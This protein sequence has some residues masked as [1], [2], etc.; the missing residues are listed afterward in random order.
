MAGVTINPVLTSNAPGTFGV[1]W[2]GLMQ[3][4]AMPDPAVRFFLASGFLDLAAPLPM[5]GG[6]AISEL[7]PT[8]PASP[9]LTPDVSLQGQIDRATNIS[10]V[11]AALSLTG[12][13]VFDQAYGMVNSPQSPVPLG[14]PGGQVMFYRLGSGARIAVAADASLVGQGSI[15]T[16]QVS[17]DWDTQTLVP[18]N[19]AYAAN[20]LTAAVFAATGGGQVTFTTTSAHGVGVGQV[21]D[22]SGGAGVTNPAGYNGTYRSIAGTTGST[23][24]GQRI[25][26][27]GVNPGAYVS[28]GQLDAGGGALPVRVLKVQPTNNMTVSYDPVAGFATWN[29][30]AAAALILI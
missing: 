4:M 6:V 18:F 2:D 22:I 10:T 9:P 8:F 28:G 5:W 16:Q 3:G 17:W 30:N 14:F 12:F 24:I 19:A 20:L 13:S 21:F 1:S 23:L 29:R 11:G 7:V 26:N 25:V 27:Q 15:I